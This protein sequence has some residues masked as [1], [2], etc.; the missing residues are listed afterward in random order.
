MNY[1]SALEKLAGRDRR[2]VGN[3]TYLEKLDGG[4]VAVRLHQTNVVTFKPDG[5]TVLNSGGWR[6][7]TTKDRI[8]TY[9]PVGVW[10]KKRVWYMTDGAEFFDGI[11]IRPDGTHDG[12]VADDRAT[13]RQKKIKKFAADYTRAFDDGRVDAPSAG[14]CFYCVMREVDTKKPLGEVTHNTEHLD[15]HI[16]ESYFVPSLLARALEVFP[17]SIACN[18]YIWGKWQGKEADCFADVGREQTEK[19]LKRYLL[20]CYGMV[21]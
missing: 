15:S 8:N 13:D 12:K 21:A 17:Q 18:A 3:N 1:Q 16:E 2:K 14:D 20:R 5:A 9:S 11:T 7:V 4:A 10:Q 19:A 6:T